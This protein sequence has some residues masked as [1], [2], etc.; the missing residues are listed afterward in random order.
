LN[1]F[2]SELRIIDSVPDMN[3]AAPFFRK[4]FKH[5][6]YVMLGEI[7]DQH[8]VKE[9]TESILANDLDGRDLR[10][11]WI[12]GKL[13]GTAV[14]IRR[15]NY[16]FVWGMYV[17]PGYLR[18]GIGRR[19]PTDLC[20]GRPEGTV[21]SVQVLDESVGALSFCSSM[22]FETVASEEVQ[23]FPNVFRSAAIMNCKVEDIGR[24]AKGI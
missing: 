19:L 5:E 20:K 18:K 15:E 14:G 13:T 22:G 21:I 24:A 23:V 12:E 1:E 6:Y 8:I 7:A 2:L 17:D 3:L 10:S 16:F 9:I 4:C 11:A